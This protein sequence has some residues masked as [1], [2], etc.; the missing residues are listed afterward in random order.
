MEM[1][2]AEFA[3]ACMTPEDVQMLRRDA[4][5]LAA[6]IAVTVTSIRD[7]KDRAEYCS[8]HGYTDASERYVFR[9]A[10]AR[11]TLALLRGLTPVETVETA[12]VETATVETAPV[13]TVGRSEEKST[14]TPKLF[15]DTVRYM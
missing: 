3:A 6:R 4:S 1:T 5:Y 11:A 2:A 12:T 10:E 7:L 8:E 13:E 9:V 14:L 15:F